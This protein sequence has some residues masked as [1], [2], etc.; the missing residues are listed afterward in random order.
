MFRFRKVLML[1]STIS[2]ACILPAA[3]GET[4]ATTQLAVHVAETS[5]IDGTILRYLD[6][7]SLRKDPEPVYPSKDI[8]VF[9]SAQLLEGQPASG[10]KTTQPAT[11]PASDQEGSTVESA[12]KVV[13]YGNDVIVRA[14]D[15][16]GGDIGPIMIRA[17]QLQINGMN[18]A[19]DKNG[20]V[21][22]VDGGN[23]LTAKRV[24]LGEAN[25]TWD[26]TSDMLILDDPKQVSVTY[27]SQ[28]QNSS[29][30]GIGVEPPSDALRSQLNLAPG[31]GLL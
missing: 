27:A 7:L 4:A 9:G 13:P 25:I 23:T 10:V 3:G 28:D 20:D 14:L 26:R 22:V 12:R 21:V 31:G 5:K 16:A 19:S 24:K 17:K 1:A 6:T 11:Q 2:A 15:K 18:V 8:V 29:Y 30:L